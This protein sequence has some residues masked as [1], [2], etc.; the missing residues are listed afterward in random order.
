MATVFVGGSAL[1]LAGAMAALAFGFAN[2]EESLVWTALLASAAAAVFLVVAY[3]LS[4]R[5]MKAAT[6][7][8]AL[9]EMIGTAGTPAADTSNDETQSTESAA[10]EPPEHDPAATQEQSAVTEEATGTAAVTSGSPTKKPS[11]AKRSSAPGN[12]AAGRPKAP[13]GA[14]VAVL[15]KKKFHRP[16]CRYAKSEGTEEMTRAAARRRGFT[17]C[18][19]CKP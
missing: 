8:A 13:E 6:K 7:Q 19:I 10:Q 11:T 9:A 14:V 5:E 2:G 15:S 12:A 17:P 1:L 4:R 16:E 18:G 3:F